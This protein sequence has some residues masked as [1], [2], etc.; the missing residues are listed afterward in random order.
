MKLAI[1]IIAPPLLLAGLIAGCL[2][3]WNAYLTEFALATEQMLFVGVMVFCAAIVLYNHLIMQ[4]QISRWRRLSDGLKRDEREVAKRFES[5][6]AE[7]GTQA[8]MDTL[9][10]KLQSIKHDFRELK[11]A[12][13]SNP[14]TGDRIQPGSGQSQFGNGNVI[15]LKSASKP[16]GKITKQAKRF[17]IPSNISDLIQ[18]GRLQIYL[19]PSVYLQKR[20]VH[21][22]EVLARLE[23]NN[24]RIAPAAVFIDKLA[25]SGLMAKADKVILAQTIGLLRSLKRRNEYPDVFWHVSPAS[26]NSKSAFR[27]IM[28]TLNA[29]SMFNKNLRIE[30]SPQ[31]LEGLNRKQN[32]RLQEIREAGFGLSL[33]NCTNLRGA[34]KLLASGLFKTVK[35]PIKA[36]EDATA[37]S[38]FALL[39]ETC[40][41]NEVDLIVTHVEREHQVIQLIDEHVTIGQGFLFSEPKKPV[42]D[43]D[44]DESVA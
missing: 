5:L 16:A 21:G 41:A 7:M 4:L 2:V 13:S 9:M 42:F 33:E 14:E 38:H 25:N 44:S 30:I 15:P 27:G 12:D 39:Q 26:L 34:N 37:S 1:S 8:D 6:S 35:I 28:E 40:R 11:S 32:L 43:K 23:L 31:A 17:R 24:G 29:N 19:Q 36:I 20:S 18:D 3:A 10:G 22:Y